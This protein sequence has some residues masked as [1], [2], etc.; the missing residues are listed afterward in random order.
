MCKFKPGISESWLSSFSFL[1]CFKLFPHFGRPWTVF[2]FYICLVSKMQLWSSF[3]SKMWQTKM[4]LLFCYC[5]RKD[6]WRS[7]KFSWK[8]SELDKRQSK[9]TNVCGTHR[10]IRT[11]Q[12]SPGNPEARG[13]R[14]HLREHTC[15]IS[16]SYYFL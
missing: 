3:F 4:Y 16:V 9:Q 14:T 11:F 13:E 7:W 2:S 5:C 12:E 1:L 8:S 6:L 10:E 15:L